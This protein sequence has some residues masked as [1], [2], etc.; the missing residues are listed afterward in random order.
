MLDF[1]LRFTE[2]ILSETIRLSQKDKDFVYDQVSF[3]LKQTKS[4]ISST[5]TNGRDKSSAVLSNIWQRASKSIKTINNEK[6]RSLAQTIEEKSKYWAD[7]DSYDNTQFDKYQMRIL[8]V[9]TTLKN[10][11]K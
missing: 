11:C 4:Y 9:E 5:R 8:Q 1:F 3:A 7:P 6:I 2:D 10:L